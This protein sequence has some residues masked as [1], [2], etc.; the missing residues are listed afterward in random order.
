M[1]LSVEAKAVSL[2]LQGKSKDEIAG[3]LGIDAERVDEIISNVLSQ[4]GDYDGDVRFGGFDK[5]LM[6]IYEV[7]KKRVMR[8]ISLERQMRMPITDTKDNLLLLL[9]ILEALWRIK[10]GKVSVDVLKSELF[11][12]G[13]EG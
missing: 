13:D 9:K 2:F 7:Q 4:S 3:I 1:D 12:G 8:Y 6:N 11:G 10:G 5:E